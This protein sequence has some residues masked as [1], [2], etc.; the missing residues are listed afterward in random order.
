M[1]NTW[2]YALYWLAAAGVAVALAFAAPSESRVMGRLPDFMSRT[3][4]QQAASAPR[5][6]PSDRTLALI[7]FGKEQ[8]SQAESWITGLNLMS[9]PSIA[10]MRMPVLNDPGDSNARS[11]AESRL[12]K[13]Y[14][15][16][17]ERANLVPVFTD[18]ASFAHAAGLSG[19]DHVFAV[20]VNRSGDVIARAEGAFDARKAETLR[21]NLRTEDTSSSPRWIGQSL[22]LPN[23]K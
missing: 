8:R 22:M 5:G 18:R 11:A 7:T 20:I 3:L 4:L 1:K 12:L 6:L 17:A 21:E 13:H 2:S 19:V 16:E 14:P 10:W 23:V 9:D 15:A